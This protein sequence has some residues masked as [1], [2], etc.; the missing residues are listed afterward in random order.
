[1]STRDSIRQGTGKSA[2]KWRGGEE[3]P[4]AETEFVAEVEE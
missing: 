2:R 1:M 3:D 4:N